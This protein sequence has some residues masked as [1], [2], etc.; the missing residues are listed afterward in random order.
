MPQRLA[1]MVGG[2]CSKEFPRRQEEQ[3]TRR[4]LHVIHVGGGCGP[5]HRMLQQAAGDC[6]QAPWSEASHSQHPNIWT[7]LTGHHCNTWR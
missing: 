7:L 4:V 1:S 6:A 5:E 2:N 3:E